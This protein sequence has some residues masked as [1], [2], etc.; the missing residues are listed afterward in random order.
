MICYL[1]SIELDLIKINDNLDKPALQLT[2]LGQVIAMDTETY[3][4]KTSY[5]ESLPWMCLV[6]LLKTP[7]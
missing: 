3:K 2:A 5:G 6:Q 1:D 4:Q 7:I